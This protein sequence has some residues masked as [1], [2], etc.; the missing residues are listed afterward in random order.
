[1]ADAHGSSAAA[2]LRSFADMLC[3][4]RFAIG[5]ARWPRYLTLAV[6]AALML[7]LL[8]Q[9]IGQAAYHLGDGTNV[10]VLD[11]AA[12]VPVIATTHPLGSQPHGL[13]APQSHELHH[14]HA[15]LA[16]L[17]ALT[18]FTLPTIG[19]GLQLIPLHLLLQNH[20][21]PPAPPP[22]IAQHS[23]YAFPC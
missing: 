23:T 12:F 3:F 16:V 22:R 13:P 11:S 21:S 10:C 7:V 4:S 17:L 8:N 20:E 18:M 5:V 14:V 6:Q 9:S 19:L 1:M 15:P 2:K